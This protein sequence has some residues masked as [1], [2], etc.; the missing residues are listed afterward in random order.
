VLFRETILDRSADMRFFAIGR[1]RTCPLNS[2]PTDPYPLRTN[3]IQCRWPRMRCVLVV[4]GRVLTSWRGYGNA[5]AAGE[6]TLL[7]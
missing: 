2:L 1:D 7:S 4:R 3:A 5:D 6:T